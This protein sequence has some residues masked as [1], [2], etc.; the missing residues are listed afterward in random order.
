[1]RHTGKRAATLFGL[2]LASFFTS[3]HAA[4][5]PDLSKDG[6]DFFEK[7]IRPVLVDR[8][9]KCHSAESGKSKGGLLVDSREGLLK[10]GATGPAVVPGDPEKSLLIRAIRYKEEELEMPPMDRL[11]PEMIADFEKWIKAGASDPRKRSVA[12]APPAATIDFEKAKQFWSFQPVKDPP[13]P[14]VKNKA[15]PKCAVDSFVLAKL[16][17]KGL[18]PS[19]PADK[20]TLIRRATFD[21]TGLPPKPEDIDAFLAD[22]SP[23]AFEKVVDRLLAST[24]YGERWGR[25]WLDV[26]RY[27][28]TAGESAD[29][30]VPE[31]YRYR[32]YVIDSFNAD[33]PYDR[34]IK[35]QIAGDLLG[36]KN[37]QEKFELLTA[38]G[39]V[40]LARR[41]SV[42]PETSHHLTIEDTID[43]TS[44]AV[45]GLTLSC[46]RCHDHK[47]DPIPSKDYYA[48]YGIFSS[49]RYPFPG[50]ENTRYQKDLV[51][52]A[53]K[54][55]YEKEIKPLE[56]KVRVI[57]DQIEALDKEYKAIEKEP[58]EP[59]RPKAL[60][61]DLP[62]NA[63]PPSS[64]AVLDVDTPKTF[65]LNAQPNQARSEIV[66]VKNQAFKS[67]IRV[68]TVAMP[69]NR[70][71]IQL[72]AENNGAIEKNDVL[73]VSFWM[74]GVEAKGASGAVSAEIILEN[75]GA[76][77]DGILE[78]RVNSTPGE[79]RHFE[80]PVVSQKSWTPGKASL[81]IRLGYDAQTVE[82]AAVELKNF[83]QAVKVVEAP[84][85]A[86]AKKSRKERFAEII[87][88]VN[89]RK[90][91]IEQIYASGPEIPKAFAI[92]EG[93]PHDSAIH[94]RGEPGKP[95]EEVRRGF[96]QVLGGQKLPEKET[97][98]GRLELAE[99]LTDSKNPL[100][101][102]VMV[103]RIWQYH[104]G[105]PIVQTPS[106]FGKQG[107]APTHPELLDHLA[108][109]FM[110]SGWSM[111]AMH[112]ML[113]L[114]QTYQ[115][116]S[117]DTAI[118]AKSAD[119]RPAAEIDATN[120]YLRIFARQRLDAEAVRDSLLAVS[121]SLD[122]SMGGEHPFPP[123]AKWNF[124]QHDQFFAM[125]ETNRRSVYV[126]QQRLRRHP[127]FATFDGADTNTTTA[128]RLLSTTPLQALFMMNDKFTH[129]QAEKFAGRIMAC[130]N[131]ENRVV[132]AYRLALGRMPDAEEIK[133][134]LKYVA[135]A[136]ERL[137]LTA[138]L[139]G[140][141][142]Q[143]AWA[144]FARALLS[145]NEFMY[146]D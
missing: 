89:E 124:T 6:L 71:E 26:A 43:T 55:Q 46:A 10:G 120:D 97:G 58:S 90:K 127:F 95:G 40:A 7:K 141:R 36:P 131:D 8:C 35:E 11:T 14:A 126:M 135:Q 64:V 106:D 145:S 31:A 9:Y 77:W 5:T 38:T 20:R 59:E 93:T 24:Q 73:L 92:V 44:R 119:G 128:I 104:F 52:L 144:S 48:L 138:L 69:V 21:L 79:W 42:A 17:E 13:I 74:R 142:Q 111:K 125:Y 86:P 22:N 54:E 30:P 109:K 23:N 96:L 87:A 63:L 80:V 123:P 67:A 134:V 19:A 27:A 99:W 56:D 34:F 112:K 140:L 61:L 18:T 41:F 83:K 4:D 129:E 57:R 45:L 15:W 81:N 108:T 16:E 94:I 53:T 91:Q 66:E 107:K 88:K 68:T 37:D 110:Q 60:T 82:I 65:T 72:H 70:W 33:K 2:L 121:G 102:R 32:N 143:Q 28:D 78:H 12:V 62:K 3:S 137:Q 139:A 50:S 136:D 133:A 39:F 51:P 25:H 29:Y 98:S 118:S 103:N 101:A 132:A 49:S 117:N 84:A 146:V 100:T 122:S 85:A 116:A 75:N 105:K 115:L 76:P 1:M 130:G 113:M 47:F 114:S